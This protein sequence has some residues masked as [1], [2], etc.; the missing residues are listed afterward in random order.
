MQGK[1]P[2]YNQRN[3]LKAYRLNP[4]NWLVQKDAPSFMQIVHRYS[5][6]VRR[7]RK[8]GTPCS[9]KEERKVRE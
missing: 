4:A 8:T 9:G 5:G 2:T 1:K 3:F 6:N 7:I